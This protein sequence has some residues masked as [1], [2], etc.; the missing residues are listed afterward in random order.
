MEVCQHLT[1]IAVSGDSKG[2]IQNHKMLLNNG[3]K[4]QTPAV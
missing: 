2:E 3:I 1:V 4:N